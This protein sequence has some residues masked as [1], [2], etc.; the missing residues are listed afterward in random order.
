MQLNVDY[1][2]RATV[3]GNSISC[4]LV[5][6]NKVVTR[7]NNSFSSGDVALSTYHASARFHDLKV[8]HP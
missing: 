5:G 1:T 4:R 8:W 3:L 2:L 6:T 7:N